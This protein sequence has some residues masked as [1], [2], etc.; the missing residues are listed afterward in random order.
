MSGER[1]LGTKEKRANSK[2]VIDLLK[3]LGDKLK[4][5][6]TIFFFDFNP[7]GIP[8]NELYG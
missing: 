4:R 7:L 6:C 5:T 1:G 8:K 3:L 2:V